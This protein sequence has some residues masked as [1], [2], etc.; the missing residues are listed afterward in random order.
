MS[1][2]IVSVLTAYWLTVCF[3]FLFHGLF[4]RDRVHVDF[5]WFDLW[6]GVYYNR[7]TGA[8]FI[9]A[10]PCFPMIVEPA[11]RHGR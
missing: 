5:V 2:I 4:H 8:M 9:C 6:I 1:D 7:P 3:L 11:R 10:V